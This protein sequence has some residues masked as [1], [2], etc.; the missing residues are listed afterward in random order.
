[1][2]LKKTDYIIISILAVVV[3]AGIVGLVVATNL[4][5]END[6]RDKERRSNVQTDLNVVE[7]N[8]TNIVN[9]VDT[10]TTPGEQ[11]QQLVNALP[12]ALTNQ[13]TQSEIKSIKL[14]YAY[15]YDVA[16]ADQMDYI[17]ILEIDCKDDELKSL[18][19]LIQNNKL[20]ESTQAA[21]TSETTYYNT[22]VVI[23]GNKVL[24]FSDKNATYKRDDKTTGVTLNTELLN[25]VAEIVNREVNKRVNAVDPTGI[26]TIV[27]TNSS[28]ASVTITDTE[29]IKTICAL[30]GCVNFKQ[31]KVKMA[32]Q[33]MVYTIELSNG[34]KMSIAS[35]GA[36]GYVIN[37][38]SKQEVKFMF[39]VEQGLET[40]FKKYAK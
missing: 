14:R 38:N 39:N 34:I 26:K 36:M 37:N 16:L 5:S 20:D 21:Q 32:D 17:E 2:K 10:N 29:E 22:Q 31:G 3:I 4:M 40:I 25:K 7:E 30:T 11:M 33:K 15:G 35:G 24:S 23:D 27:I 13:S 19:Q 28:N 12:N 9:T 8:E 18:A 6:A 1:M